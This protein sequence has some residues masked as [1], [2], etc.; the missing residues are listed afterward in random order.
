MGDE[1]FQVVYDRSALLP[2]KL[3]LCVALV[4]VLSVYVLLSTVG[5]LPV[6]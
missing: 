6:V 1:T 2:K 3:L 4:S 5:C